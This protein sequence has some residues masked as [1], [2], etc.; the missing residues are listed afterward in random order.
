M[1]DLIFENLWKFLVIKISNFKNINL[2][3]FILYK[4]K[5]CLL[6]YYNVIGY[7]LYDGKF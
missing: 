7:Q 1:V 6:K 5:V 2:Y 4:I 3:I